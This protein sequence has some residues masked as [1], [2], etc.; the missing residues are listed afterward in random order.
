MKFYSKRFLE[1][2]CELEKLNEEF[3][4]D[5]I[6]TEYKNVWTPNNEI[7]LWQVPR[8]T[9]ILLNSFVAVSRAKIVLELGTSAG[10]SAIWMANAVKYNLGKVFTIEIAKPKCD[11]ARQTFKKAGLEEYIEL[12]NGD[13][14]EVLESWQKSTDLV[15]MD[16]DKPNYLKYM[17]LLEPHLKSGSIIVA[18]NAMNYYN[19]MIDYIEYVLDDPRYLSFPMDIDNGLFVSMVL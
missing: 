18:D 9:G 7:K 3:H 14:S 12:I 10:Y 8:T 4:I 13:I 6:P 1:V 19:Y 2:V 17:K 11:M 5:G 16:A 15:F